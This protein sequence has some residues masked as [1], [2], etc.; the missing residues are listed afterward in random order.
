MRAR[1]RMCER[2]CICAR[3]RTDSHARAPVRTLARTRAARSDT[4]THTLLGA[5]AAPGGRVPA[6]RIR[7][8]ECVKAGCVG[9]RAREVEYD[10]S[11]HAHERM[12]STRLVCGLSRP[13][14]HYG[15][16]TDGDSLRRR[17]ARAAPSTRNGCGKSP[18]A[19]TGP[20][21]G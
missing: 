1:L 5:P 12:L 11:Q 16:A 6:A 19:A 9:P 14:A 13:R 15:T 21:H 7:V 3:T 10:C 2:A 4:H 8:P 20:S 17:A 18:E